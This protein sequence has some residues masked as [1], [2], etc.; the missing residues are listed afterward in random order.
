MET[1]AITVRLP[2]DLY[3]Q[4]RLEAFE[5]RNSQADII[6]EALTERYK[7]QVATREGGQ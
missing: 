5:T 1:Q 6:R 4:L 2:T 3:E 7:R